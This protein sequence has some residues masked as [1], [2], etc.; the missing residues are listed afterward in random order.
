[1]MLERILCPQICL[2]S[3]VKGACEV[4]VIS[5]SLVIFLMK[6]FTEVKT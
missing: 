5:N 4:G 2:K 3:H 1:M 6:P